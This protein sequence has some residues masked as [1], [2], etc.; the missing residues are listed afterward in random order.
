MKV[1]IIEEQDRK[2]NVAGD[3]YTHALIMDLQSLQQ[4]GKSV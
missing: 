4:M 2:S 1:S 3:D